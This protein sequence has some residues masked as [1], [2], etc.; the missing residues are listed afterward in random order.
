MTKRC[1]ICRA[2]KPLDAFPSDKSRPDGRAYRCKVCQR[3]YRKT[4]YKERPEVK[5]YHRAYRRRPEVKARKNRLRRARYDPAQERRR[6]AQR[7]AKPRYRA[8]MKA[9]KAA[10]RA[11]LARAEGSVSADDIRRRYEAQ[12]GRC[13]WC[14]VKLDDY[15]VDHVIPL[16]KGGADSP[17]NI[18]V[19]CPRCNLSKND[20]LPHDF[21]GRLF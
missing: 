15:H 8:Q 1:T 9:R 16:S 14:G 12:Q 13:H 18:C 21:I 3:E 4:R 17:A 5:A 7:R 20:K 11:R 2:H 6:Y 19:S 10:Y